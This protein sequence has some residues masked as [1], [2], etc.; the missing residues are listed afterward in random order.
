MRIAG[1]ERWRRSLCRRVTA[2]TLATTCLC[3][4]LHAEPSV[5]WT[6][7]AA[8]RHAI[9]LL[10]DDAHLD[11]PTTQ[12]PL[13]RGAVLR[14]LEALPSELPPALD[15]ARDRLLR[16]I[17]A[18]EGGALSMTLRTHADALPG[19]G[20]DSTPG[21][22]LAIRSPSLTAPHLAL[23]VGGRLEARADADRSGAT[24]RLDESAIAIEG[25]GLQ[26]QA[27]S[28]RSW[29]GPG[30]QSA[31]GLSNNAPA[32]S[33]IGLQRASATTSASPWLAWMGPWNADVFVGRAEDVTQPADPM[34]VGARLT[35]RP[36]THLEI[37]LTR[38]AQWG[39]K[40]RDMSAHSLVRLLTGA[41]ANAD[42]IGDQPSDPGNQ[43][44]GFDLRLR[45]PSWLR[46]ATYAQL[47][48]EDEASHLPSRYLG[49]YGIEAWSEDGRSR[50][51]AEYA[52]TGCRSPIGRPPYKGCAYRNY[53]YP[54][55]YVSANRW[56]GASVGPDS[57]LVTLGWIDSVDDGAVS[58]HLGRVG[59][60]AGTYSPLV[61]D[62]RTSGRL[63]GLSVRR[64]FAWGAA[65]LTPELDWLRV[66][67]RSGPWTEARLG[68][69]L[70]MSLDDAGTRLGWNGGRSSAASE[71]DLL[72][73]AMLGAA[74]LG[75]AALLDPS[76]ERYAQRH[77]N[78]SSA[79]NLHAVGNA[80]PYVALGLAGLSW[81][82]ER[83]S[84]RGDLGFA[85]ASAGVSAALAAQVLK[86]ATDRARPTDGLGA[87]N[88]GD[89]P[90]AKSSFPS[91]HAS[92]AWAVLTPYAKQYD[93]PWLYG[94][95]ALTNASRVMGRDH[96]LSDTVAGAMLGYW[97]GDW[98]YQRNTATAADTTGVRVRLTPNSV[99][100]DLPLR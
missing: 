97:I 3:A 70:R 56:L 82:T 40:G 33:A 37:G 49:L 23:Q 5:P 2:G 74:V 93:A 38:T 73:R 51:F 64:G 75:G 72:T 15:A 92:L 22:S 85:A 94:V 41:G 30:W 43:L 11:L 88:F 71:S 44:A 17:R 1:S 62:P 42:N 96:W 29:W 69:N 26:L 77:G 57:R 46:C 16:E 25:L 59:S 99:V 7:S 100:L 83:G 9:Q 84:A 19:F 58:L 90:R 61:D 76:V 68:I 27:W 91:I 63:Y 13:P 21:S 66:D 36:F 78:G 50:F 54:E 45:C 55:G 6:P 18:H 35:L 80:L 10:V 65:T 4:S 47:A 87:R 98:F 31:L 14:A 32:M 39:G 86:V 67:T 24:A 60:R 52:E 48:G 79:K 53:A 89:T 8:G 81:A 95:A 28:H 20:D 12:W 34:I